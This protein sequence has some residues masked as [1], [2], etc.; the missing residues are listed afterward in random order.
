MRGG[1]PTSALRQRLS[2]L[3]FLRQFS[4]RRKRAR[5]LA[6]ARAL[7]SEN[8]FLLPDEDAR[9]DRLVGDFRR[10]IQRAVAKSARALEIGPSYSPI[11]PKTEGYNVAI[12]DHADQ[13]ELRQKYAAHGVDVGRIEP[14]DFFWRDSSIAQ[15]VGSATF[16][17]I[18][19]SHVIEHAPDLVQF[20]ADCSAILNASGRIYLIVPDK[21][22]CF[23]FFQP[24]SD[25]AKVLGDHRE[26]RTRHPYESFYRLGAA[27][28]NG[29]AITWDQSGIAELSFTHG[30]PK[31]I[32]ALAEAYA[33]WPTYQ[34]THENF[35][36]PASFLM[37]IDELRYL[38][39]A[40]L[41]VTM[42]T[43]PRGCEF[44]VTLGKAPAAEP[45]PQDFL[46]R[47]LAAYRFVMTEEAERVRSAIG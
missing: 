15:A 41:E 31:V 11:L 40:D 1:E 38:R 45:A 4:M 26:K 46:A 22:Y 24:L 28:K 21:R 32:H 12:I 9:Q 3:P 16:D 43:R 18:V 10:Y 6:A 17:A 20:L 37:L 39:A 44:F 5:E 27:V 8:Y 29:G 2:S 13:A 7:L 42:L 19:A 47:K 33:Q 25:A 35:F 23:D 30:D 34:D 36:T 14:V